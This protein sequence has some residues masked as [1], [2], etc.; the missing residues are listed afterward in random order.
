MGRLC[1][2]EGEG[3]RDASA[4]PIEGFDARMARIWDQDE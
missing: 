3:R 2:G 1:E 4:K